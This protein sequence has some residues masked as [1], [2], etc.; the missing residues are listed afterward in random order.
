MYVCLWG[1][2]QAD[3]IRLALGCVDPSKAEVSGDGCPAVGNGT[4]GGKQ[5]Q[6]REQ[7]REQRRDGQ[8]LALSNTADNESL[9]GLVRSEGW[10]WLGTFGLPP[11]PPGQLEE[12]VRYDRGW[13]QEVIWG[14][15]RG[16][17]ICCG[18]WS[19]HH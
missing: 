12:E 9:Q 7:Q 11:V 16:I 3:V 6:Q 2:E 18:P 14:G 19:F 1:S 15:A 5:Q 17:L 8:C 10:L 13:G 4:G